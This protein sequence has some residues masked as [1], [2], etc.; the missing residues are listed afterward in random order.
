MLCTPKFT[1]NCQ[2]I[3]GFMTWGAMK[4]RSQN[5]PPNLQSLA[6]VFYNFQIRPKGWMDINPSG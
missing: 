5:G 1:N 3:T 2:S 4:G 6:S